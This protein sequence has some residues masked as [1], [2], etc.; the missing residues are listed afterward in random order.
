MKKAIFILV[1]I[2]LFKPVF[3]IVEYGLNYGYITKMLCINKERPKL[4][5]NGKCYLIKQLAKNFDIEKPV[6]ASKKNE[7]QNNEILFLEKIKVLGNSLFFFGRKKVIFDVYSN[8]YF[9]K[10][11]SAV[12]RPPIVVS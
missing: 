12:F 11:R 10:K 4:H 2:I 6:S 3:P 9:Y 1:I 5:C 7:G 8:H